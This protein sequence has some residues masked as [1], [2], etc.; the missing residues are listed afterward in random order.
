MDCAMDCLIHGRFL[1]RHDNWLAAIATRFD[2]A[3]FVVMAGLVAD[4]VAEV[5]VDSPDSVT[6]PIQRSL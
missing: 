3:A 5:H 6:E 1:V 2:H 4:C